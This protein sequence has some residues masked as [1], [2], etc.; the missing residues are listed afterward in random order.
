MIPLTFHTSPS[1]ASHAPLS[2]HLDTVLIHRIGIGARAADI[3]GAFTGGIPEAAKATGYKMPYHFVVEEDGTCVQC[4]R[5]GVQGPHARSWNSHSI[6]VGMVGDFRR[7]GPLQAQ[8][9]SA[10]LLTALL[11]APQGW[12]VLGHDQA[13][14]GSSDP[15]KQCPGAYWD[16]DLFMQDVVL[17]LPR[18]VDI[19]NFWCRVRC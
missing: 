2:D 9:R 10:V 4:L 16:M 15:S 11:R 13:P 14:G 5:L 17:A 3:V 18:G 19:N 1:E 6:G 12:K 7:R 8:W